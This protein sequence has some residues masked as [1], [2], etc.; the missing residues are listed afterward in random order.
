MNGREKTE[1][2]AV[3]RQNLIPHILSHRAKAAFQGQRDQHR[4]TI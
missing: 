2:S 3:L 4:P 1:V